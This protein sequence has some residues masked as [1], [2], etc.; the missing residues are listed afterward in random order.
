MSNYRDQI[1]SMSMETY[2]SLKRSVEVGRWPDGRALSPEQRQNTMQA[3][4]AWGQL[5]LPEDEQLGQINKAGK[6]GDQCDEPEEN[7]L[8]WKD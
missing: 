5:H 3:V 1:Q 8:T 6:E 7:T 2:Q 4:I